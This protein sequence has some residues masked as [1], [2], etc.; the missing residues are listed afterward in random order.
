MK[1][2]LTA[3]SFAA[4]FSTA[5]LLSRPS[6]AGFLARTS[7]VPKTGIRSIQG[8]ATLSR[9]GGAARP[10][11]AAQLGAQEITSP[12]NRPAPTPAQTPV[13][14]E[15]DAQAA[16]PSSQVPVEEILSQSDVILWAENHFSV[17]GLDW[18]IANLGRLKAAGVTQLALENL[19]V[20]C[21]PELRNYLEGRRDAP[22]DEAFDNYPPRQIRSLLA[23]AR[24]AGVGIIAM[25]RPRLAWFA[26]IVEL[27]SRHPK[28]PSGYL[29][30]PD[31][32]ERFIL[33]A[34]NLYRPGLNEAVAEVAMRQ[35]NKFMASRLQD[36]L[37]PGGKALVLVGFAHVGLA[38][39]LGVENIFGVPAADYGNLPE[40]LEKLALR[41]FSLVPTGGKFFESADESADHWHRAA[42]YARLAQ[43]GADPAQELFLRLSEKAA[44]YHMGRGGGPARFSSD[45]GSPRPSLPPAFSYRIDDLAEVPLDAAKAG[46]EIGSLLSRDEFSEYEAG[47]WRKG[48]IEIMLTLPEGSPR[49]PTEDVY[50]DL[51]LAKGTQP[52]VVAAK[53]EAQLR[54]AGM[55]PELLQAHDARLIGTIRKINALILDAP[56]DASLLRELKALDFTIRIRDR[57]SDIPADP[58]LF[59]PAISRAQITD[60]RQL[61]A[62]TGA[63]K[64][65]A[66][67]KKVLGEPLAPSRQRAREQELSPLG[68]GLRWL[69]ETF[70]RFV[71]GVTAVNP[72][73]PWAILDSWVHTGH[74]FLEERF[75]RS[76]FNE[77]SHVDHGTHT[78]STVVAMDIFNFSGRNYNI[79]PNGSIS[80]GK[81]ALL[82]SQAV[83]DGALA[84]T[85]SWGEWTGSPE[86]VPVELFMKTAAE[87]I[88][89]NIAAG[90]LG[91]DMSD[92]ISTPGIAYFLTDL[93][94]GRRSFPK[95]VKRIKTIGAADA[96]GSATD[97]TADGPGSWA[98][99]LRPDL[100]PDFPP[101]PDETTVGRYLL[102]ATIPERGDF[103]PELGGQGIIH[104]GTSMST[105]AGFGAFLLL[106]R[107]CLVLLSDYL[108]ELPPRK[109]ALYAMDIA[110][111]AMSATARRIAPAIKSGDGFIDVWAAFHY[112]AALLRA[113]DSRLGPRLR[114]FLRRI[115]GLGGY[116]RGLEPGVRAALAQDRLPELRQGSAPPLAVIR[117][118]GP[119][120]DYPYPRGTEDPKDPEPVTQTLWGPAGT[121]FVASSN[122][123][124]RRIDP[125]TGNILWAY[126]GCSE[127]SILAMALSADG[128]VLAVAPNDNSLH[129]V[130]VRTGE[131]YRPKLRGIGAHALAFHPLDHDRI[132][133]GGNDRNAYLIDVN[134]GEGLAKFAGHGKMISS[135]L[136]SPDGKRLYTGSLDNSAR[137]WT[138]DPERF[139]QACDRIYATLHESVNALALSRDGSVLYTGGAYAR[140]WNVES[141]SVRVLRS[142]LVG[143]KYW[144][145]Q[146]RETPDGRYLI[147]S[148]NAPA[149]LAWETA[150][151]RLT[152]ILRP[153]SEPKEQLSTFDIEAGG[154][155]LTGSEITSEILLWDLAG[156]K[157]EPGP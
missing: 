62:I 148:H 140:A 27:A 85:N 114:E 108:P 8:G 32:L 36:A 68:R 54:Q 81:A 28:V 100:F 39:G 1:R 29:T 3:L 70:Y 41:S 16:V 40:E 77:P 37:R 57:P 73:L 119:E 150:T 24:S 141:G 129:F 25:Q 99:T 26:Q 133:T 96:D 115:F 118:L 95:A 155:L 17:S 78:A 19:P 67:L 59:K 151:G 14:A 104:S 128:R 126:D 82:L 138:I 135:L 50:G 83:A 101:K 91:G 51:L 22:P 93:V 86:Y 10:Q 60:F 6:F 109:L 102:G 34:D 42:L 13:P 130:D 48:R 30:D 136:P 142:T 112:A 33:N 58:D 124:L 134:T 75:E 84:T 7:L 18:I 44:I 143:S 153:A 113:S 156:L 46:S 38:D 69:R 94:L 65:Q 131:A 121:A 106:T 125:A 15:S 87:G 116:G 66:E 31:A 72:N 97:F 120:L 49:V 52:A 56:G 21:E 117:P 132:F 98:T 20:T 79:A 61:A 111:H 105:P 11:P 45:P 107:A 154:K 4:A 123:M 23:A 90:N 147:T 53:L 5:L 145:S 47:R 144:V 12:Q 103:L 88:H 92:T 64:L 76:V 149:L 63:D 9:L 110:R 80:E 146:L 89:H 35:R 43:T 122:G 139:E 71:L 55:P 127:R 2:L 74:R 152:A 137:R 157:P